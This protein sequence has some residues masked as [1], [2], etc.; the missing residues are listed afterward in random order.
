V[1]YK[2][3]FLPRERRFDPRIGRGTAQEFQHRLKV[4]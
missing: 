2:Q 3:Q 4:S 1:V